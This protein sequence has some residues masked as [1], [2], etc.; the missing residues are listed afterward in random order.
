MSFID[1]LLKREAPAP[2]P[3]EPV[4][5]PDSASV[6]QQ[7]AYANSERTSLTVAA[8]YRAVVLRA[9][10]MSQ[11]VMQYQRRIGHNIYAEDRSP[12]GKKLNYLL[13]L[14]PNP[15]I[16]WTILMRQ[17]EVLR[18]IYGNAYIYVKYNDYE[19][20]DGLYICASAAYNGFNDTYTVV[21]YVGNLLSAPVQV[22]SR[23]VIHLRNTISFDGGF[24]GVSLLQFAGRALNT[25]ATQDQLVLGTAAKGGS[26]KL[27]LQEQQQATMGVGRVQTTKMDDI[28]DKFKG[29]WN[30][31]DDIMYVPNVADIHDFSQSLQELTIDALRKFSVLDVAR[32]TGVPAIML[33]DGSNSNYKTPESATNEFLSRTIAPL[34]NEWEDELNGKLLTFEEFG[35]YQFHL[36]S[37]PLFRLDRTS[38]A[39]FNKKCL[40]MGIFSINELRAQYGLPPIPNG[41]D[42]Y[43]STNL[44]IAGSDKLRGTATPSKPAPSNPAPKDNKGEGKDGK[45]G[46]EGKD[47]KE[48]KS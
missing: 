6:I 30:A 45:G 47:K 20:V 41:D 37:K 23:C 38:E 40:E 34:M 28:K 24:T 32:F 7:I 39:D 35:E 4:N 21:Y 15:R 3:E 5:K 10:T 2:K 44:A 16:N 36:E 18:L 14:R 25:A 11:L 8:F 29:D 1:K 22:P 26:K 19:E 12:Y 17:I 27:V 13:Q 43:L 46:S 33:M 48:D 31:G 42:H 9:D